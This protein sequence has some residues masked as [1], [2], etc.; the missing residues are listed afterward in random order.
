MIYLDSSSSGL[1]E[2]LLFKSFWMHFWTTGLWKPFSTAEYS[3]LKN[4]VN[5]ELWTSG[6]IS[7][8]RASKDLSNHMCAVG[9][10]WDF[11]ENGSP[12]N[13]HRFLKNHKFFFVK[14]NQKYL[15]KLCFMDHAVAVRRRSLRSIEILQ[16]SLENYLGSMLFSIDTHV[17]IDQYS[18]VNILTLKY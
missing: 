4:S 6:S 16:R 10:E 11:A 7:F 2:S 9:R 5:R 18:N 13:Q 1:S 8:D 17:L 14:L 3:R 15:K 12:E